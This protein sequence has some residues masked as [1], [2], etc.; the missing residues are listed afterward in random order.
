MEI[1][2]FFVN[3]HEKENNKIK[4]DLTNNRHEQQ[5]YKNKKDK[6]IKKCIKKHDKLRIVYLNIRSL[7]NKLQELQ[8]TLNEMKEKP[9]II[10]IGETWLKKEEENFFQIDEY[11][12]VFNSRENTRGGGLVMYINKNIKYETI[13]NTEFEKSHV[14]VAKLMDYEIKICGYYRSPATKVDTFFEHLEKQLETNEN[15][16]CLGDTNIDLFK[17]ENKETN[18][19]LQILEANNYTILNNKNENEYTYNMNEKKSSIESIL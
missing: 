7:R 3:M 5:K 9:H 2:S 11:E 10:V 19:F 4:N 17:T 15:L 16:I 13:L 14:I 18:T 8:L 1:V 6:I 12:A